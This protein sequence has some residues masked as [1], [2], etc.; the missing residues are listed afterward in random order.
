MDSGQN[1]RGQ[2]R[3][4]RVSENRLKRVQRFTDN[5][6]VRPWGIEVELDGPDVS[7][8]LFLGFLLEVDALKQLV[9]SVN[10]V[11]ELFLL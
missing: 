9:N 10:E 2:H 11:F 3:A 7:T 4:R 5:G 6:R 8:D 1:S